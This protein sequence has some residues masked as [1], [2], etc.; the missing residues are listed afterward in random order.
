MQDLFSAI[1]AAAKT[2]IW[3]RGVTLAREGAV[4]AEEQTPSERVYRVR[5]PGLPVPPRATLYTEELEWACDCD[6]A[7]DP[8]EHVIAAVIAARDAE[9]QGTQVTQT[10]EVRPLLGYRLKRAAGPSLSIERVVLSP[11]G[12]EVPLREPLSRLVAQRKCPVDPNHEDLEIDRLLTQ[13]GGKDSRQGV[14]RG[15]SAEA[16]QR[17]LGALSLSSSVKLD[18]KELRVSLEPLVPEAVAVDRPGRDGAVLVEL[19]LT[20]PREAFEVLDR[21]VGLR[22]GVL[23]PLGA[24]ELVGS[25]WERLP[26]RRAVRSDDLGDLVT[27]VL[28]EVE[29]HLTVRIESRILPSRGGLER[30]RIAFDMT[31]QGHTLSVLPTLVYGEPATVRIDGDKV[32]H[33]AGAIPRRDTATEQKLVRQLRDELSLVPGRLVHFDGNDAARF[34]KRLQAFQAGSSSTF[35]R[36][37]VSRARL[38]PHLTLDETQFDVT[39]TTEEEAPRTASVEAVYRAFRDGL[40]VVPLE[41]GGWA[42]LPLD[43][44]NRY[45]EKVA[46][47]FAARRSD[48]RLPTYASAPLAAL[49]RE[50]GEPPPPSFSHLEPLFAGFDE[51]PRAPL[52]PQLPVTL[53]PYQVAGVDWLAFL[54]RSGLGGILADDMGLGK[55]LQTLCAI[56]GKTLVVCPKSVVFNWAAE[57][58]RFRPDL[59]VNVFHG[60]QRKLD[61][62]DITLTT[63]AVVRLDQDLLAAGAWETVVLDEAQAIKNPDSQAARALF[64]VSDA[65]PNGCFRL[66]LSGTPLENR[67]DELWSLFRFTHPGLLGTRGSFAERF[68]RPIQDG[69]P[70]AGARLRQLIKPFLLRRVKHEVAR[71]LPPRTDVVMTVELEQDQRDLYRAIYAAKNRE[72]VASLEAG[73]SV[74]EALEALLRLR[75]AACHPA[76]VPGQ[77][78]GS[79]AKFEALLG[80]LEDAAADGHKA[81]VFSQWTSLLDLLEPELESRAL[82]FTRLDGST[83]DRG[84]VVEAFQAEQGPPVFLSSLKAGGTG[85]NLTAADHVFLLDPWWNPAAEEQAA[86]RAHRIGQ[87]RPVTVYRLIAKDTIEEGILALQ[88]RKRALSEVALGEGGAAQGITREDLLSLLRG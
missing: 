19:S 71:D 46:D 58:A 12:S 62:A 13:A 20:A 83:R 63:Y 54:A 80:A 6:S 60:P 21:G 56:R 24:T 64:A 16:Y 14:H 67:L 25:R 8:C 35:S 84:A 68:S 72:V 39:F 38:V 10:T 4:T 50:L 45:G 77:V 15:L 49:C 85:L 41:D 47:L 81:I 51:L 48:G 26:L 57:I 22:S 28:P 17:V 59:R 43:W 18:G 65:L 78:G 74:L 36:E 79:S 32:V 23:Q 61:D 42:P 31:P 86:G 76:L 55:T 2:A 34:A 30:P 9:S 52:P 70:E 37:V 82:G 44:L 29:K 1:K 5:S 40:D 75:Q 11:D 73:G 27:K 33:L 53:R 3:S 87:S 69:S 66:A 7:H 88:E